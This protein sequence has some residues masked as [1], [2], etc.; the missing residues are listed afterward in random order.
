MKKVELRKRVASMGAF[1]AMGVG[2]GLTC[3]NV[4]GNW[5]RGICLVAFCAVAFFPNAFEWVTQWDET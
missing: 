3:V 5:G 4:T 1:T 2:L